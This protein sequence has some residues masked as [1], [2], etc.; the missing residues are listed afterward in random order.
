M[1]QS[2]T[3]RRNILE[4]IF[5]ALT[6][7]LTFTTFLHLLI[8]LDISTRCHRFTVSK[9]ELTGLPP[10]QIPLQGSLSSPNGT[11]IKLS[12]QARKLGDPLGPPSSPSSPILSRFYLPSVSGA[13]P[14]L[15]IT[16]DTTLWVPVSLQAFPAWAITVTS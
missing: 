5:F 12:T 9:T 2:P 14:F 8:Q 15:S 13:H 1:P 6:T 7:P 3:C 4:L 11:T 10:S 16:T